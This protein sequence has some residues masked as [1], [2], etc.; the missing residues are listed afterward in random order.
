MTGFLD[1]LVGV[2][3][4]VVLAVIG[5][6]V[7]GEAAVFLGFVFPGETA[8]LIGGFMASTGRMSVV[9]LAIVVV[10]AAIVGDTV[11][12]QVGKHYGPRLLRTRMFQKHQ[13]R[14]ASAKRFLD[15]RGAPAIF[16]GRFTAFLRA[17]TP[18][19]A[20]L[21]RMRYR[22]F[23]VWNALG[24]IVWG[25]GCVALGF[26]AGSSYKQA[27][28]WLGRGGGIAVGALVLVALGIWMWQ[29]HRRARSR[30]DQMSHTG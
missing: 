4:P 19:L 25:I 8:V 15:G 5:A 12:Y 22:R 23:L 27:E 14:V 9:L 11:G 30:G 7:F 1:A 18:G 17:V 13:E 10:L 20:G 28:K 21:S 3:A 29:R 26:V 16:I 24:G 6:L 2:P